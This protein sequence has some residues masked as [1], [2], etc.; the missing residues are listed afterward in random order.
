MTQNNVI[1][2][3]IDCDICRKEMRERDYGQHVVKQQS[4]KQTTKWFSSYCMVPGV[5]THPHDLE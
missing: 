4:V 3:A 2:P 5:S 1:T